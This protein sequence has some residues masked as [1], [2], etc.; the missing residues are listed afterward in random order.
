MTP[1]RWRRASR[2]TSHSVLSYLGPTNKPTPSLR[3]QLHL[4]PPGNSNGWTWKMGFRKLEQDLSSVNV[5]CL[6]VTVFVFPFLA[7]THFTSANPKIDHS[8]ITIAWLITKRNWVSALSSLWS[9]LAENVAQSSF[10]LCVMVQLISHSLDFCLS[11]IF[12][13]SNMSYLCSASYIDMFFY[14]IW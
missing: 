5:L 6:K 2:R 4:W 8:A 7:F 3:N 14:L 1:E 10:L 11:G 9:Y 12:T 13:L